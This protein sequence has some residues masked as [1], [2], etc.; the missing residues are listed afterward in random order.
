[1][2]EDTR[3]QI[4]HM[5]EDT[6]GVYLRPDPITCKAIADLTDLCKR[7]FGIVSAAAF[8]PHATL[9]GAVPSNATAEEFIEILDP[10]LTSTPSFPVYNAGIA[11]KGTTS[12]YNID[13]LES[14]G[15]NPHLLDLATRVNE[16]IAPITAYQ[17]GE[18][19]QPF[20]PEKFWAHFSLASHDLRRRADLAD[21]VEDFLRAIPV[22]YSRTFTAD[23][24]T[25][26]RF[27]S[28]DWNSEWWHDLTWEHVK[29]WRLPAR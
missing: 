7:Q 15:Q 29:S 11:R 16:I 2:A 9:A 14:G 18:W 1:M 28:A 17:P 26:F 13:S 25:L 5:T 21:E 3:E 6:W 4:N 20:E 12:Y 24:I 19:T 10:L 27:H 22:D 23:T 8:A